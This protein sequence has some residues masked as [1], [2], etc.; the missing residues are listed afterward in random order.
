LKQNFAYDIPVHD[1]VLAMRSELE[2]DVGSMHFDLDVFDKGSLTVNFEYLRVIHL[3]PDQVISH[4]FF[5]PSLLFF[6]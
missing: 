6:V 2:P 3:K 5:F 1:I 4:F